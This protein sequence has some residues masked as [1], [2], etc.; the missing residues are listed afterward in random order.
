MRARNYQV[1]AV[2][3]AA[4][5]HTPVY[6]QPLKFSPASRLARCTPLVTAATAGGT[7]WTVQSGVPVEDSTSGLPLLDALALEFERYARA[8]GIDLERLLKSAGSAFASG[9]SLTDEDI[10]HI[11]LDELQIADES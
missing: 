8:Q 6:A 9:G 2:A 3:V 7:H 11:V 1:A 4:F 10:E 5:S